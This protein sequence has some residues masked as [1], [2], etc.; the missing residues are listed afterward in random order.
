MQKTGLIKNEMLQYLKGVAIRLV[1]HGNRDTLL[2]SMLVTR[3]KSPLGKDMS[4]TGG[5]GK[6]KR[7]GLALVKNHQILCYHLTSSNNPD[8]RHDSFSLVP[9]YLM[10][11]S[12]PATS[13]IIHTLHDNLSRE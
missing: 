7:L 8:F 10:C 6:E 12:S 3:A 2:A 9:Y 11:S 13:L 4:P 5:R 1:S